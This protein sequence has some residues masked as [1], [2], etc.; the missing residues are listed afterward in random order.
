[1]IIKE[2]YRH[3]LPHFQQ[4]GQW[5]FITCVLHN[6]IPHGVQFKYSDKVK[7]A[8]LLYKNL[9]KHESGS[10]GYLKARHE[11]LL[12]RKKYLYLYDSLLAKSSS[13][14]LS[15]NKDI[16]REIIEGALKFWDGKCLKNH[17][18]CIMPNHFHWV[19]TLFDKNEKGEPVYLQNILHSVKLFTAR[20]I[21]ENENL[22]GILWMHE[23]FETTIK[24]DR[25]YINVVNYT[26]KNPVKARLVKFWKDWK[27]TYVE[28]ELLVE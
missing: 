25:H 24:S 21:N 1:M 12:L 16:N 11:Y 6:A 10:E 27:G 5:Y 26:V 13:A 7:T 20:R 9:Q 15:L 4:P 17:A 14:Q 22:K 3:H 23:S 28:D 19:V 8:F 18:W 2:C